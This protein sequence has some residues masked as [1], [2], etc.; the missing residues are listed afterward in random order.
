MR[1][2]LKTRVHLRLLFALCIIAG[3]LSI[4]TGPP[5][6]VSQP[7]VSTEQVS[8]VIIEHLNGDAEHG[9]SFSHERTTS[10]NHTHSVKS[11]DQAH[12]FSFE[13]Y[14]PGRLLNSCLSLLKKEEDSSVVPLFRLLLYPKHWF[15]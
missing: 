2:D 3:V 9:T 7:L 4:R 1:I 15:W 10:T 6:M 11:R 8:K 14:E 5:A 12:I 13:N